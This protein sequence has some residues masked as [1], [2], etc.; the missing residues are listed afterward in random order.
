M[1]CAVLLSVPGQDA[2]KKELGCWLGLACLFEDIPDQAGT[3]PLQPNGMLMLHKLE[4]DLNE[5]ISVREISSLPN[6]EQS[7]NRRLAAGR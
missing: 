1:C 6:T 4:P 2:D 3:L 5:I 7:M